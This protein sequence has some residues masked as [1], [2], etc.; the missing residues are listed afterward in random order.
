MLITALALTTPVRAQVVL[1][2]VRDGFGQP[3]PLVHVFGADNASAFNANVG[4]LTDSVGRYRLRL[5]ARVPFVGA[6]RIGYTP[7]LARSLAWIGSDTVIVDFVLRSVPYA[8]ATVYAGT[9]LCLRLDSLPAQS[10]VRTLWDGAVATIAARDAFLNTYRYTQFTT[11]HDLIRRDSVRVYDTTNTV[12]PRRQPLPKDLLSEPLATYRA[13]SF[14]H[15]ASLLKLRSPGDRLLMHPQFVKRFCFDDQ[16]VDAG[17]GTVAVRFEERGRHSGQVKVTGTMAFTRGIPG[18]SRVTFEYVVRD[19]VVARSQQ[20]F[21]LIDVTG[22]S[23]PLTTMTSLTL[24][25]PRSN[26][27]IG[28]GSMKARYGMFTPVGGR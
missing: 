5:G 17:D 14:F 12:E 25:D 11:H 8:L 1:G 10:E 18:P 7:E 4:T 6:R 16:V 3:V 9:N 2:T 28:E 19:K 21:E 15:R 22:S 27:T 26:T 24:F 23:F 13:P 20:L